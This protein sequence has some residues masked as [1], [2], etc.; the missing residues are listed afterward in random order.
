MLYY[1]IA[2]IIII[3]IFLF[4]IPKLKIKYHGNVGEKKVRRILK[5]LDK[6]YKV[7]NHFKIKGCEIDHLVFKNK[8]IFVIE[9]KNYIGY[10]AGNAED[11]YLNHSSKMVYSPLY[12]NNGH[13]NVIKRIYPG[14]KVVSVICFCG[15]C[16]VDIKGKVNAVIL[17]DRNL[18]SFLTN[19]RF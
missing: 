3:I 1:L 5:Q 16:K 14:Y 18:Y 2:A 13:C 15:N 7:D 12:Q 11:K 19:Y 8:T 6:S 10:L 4:L 9:T 17:K